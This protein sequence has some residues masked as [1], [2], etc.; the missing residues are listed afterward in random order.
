MGESNKE[1]LGKFIR[2]ETEIAPFKG[3][4][5]ALGI[6]AETQADSPEQSAEEAIDKGLNEAEGISTETRLSLKDVLSSAIAPYLR[7]PKL[8][9]SMIDARTLGLTTPEAIKKFLKVH[10]LDMENKEDMEYLQTVFTESADFYDNY[11]R[12]GKQKRL[13]PELRDFKTPEGI[14][15]IFMTS[16]G[17]GN[18]HFITQACALLRTAAVINYME[19]DVKFALAEKIMPELEKTLS[20]NFK[21][22][23]EFT[24]KQQRE[25]GVNGNGKERKSWV[26]MPARSGQIPM[27]IMG[28]ELR[29]KTREQIIVKLLRRAEDRMESILDVLGFRVYTNNASDAM[30]LFYHM[31]FEPGTAIFPGYNIRLSETKNVG[32]DTEKLRMVLGDTQA[33]EDLFK[34]LSVTVDD[35]EILAKKYDPKKDNEYSMPEYRALQ[36]TFDIDL[37]IKDE[38][39]KRRRVNF[40]VEVQIVDLQAKITNEQKAPHG[41]YKNG[42]KAAVIQRVIGN[43][44]ATAF[45]KHK[46]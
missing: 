2:E 46:K 12:E 41:E 14:Y 31:F 9:S 5:R 35:S 27:P 6:V 20:H 32:I 8:K 4:A 3:A 26:F 28:F 18:R 17:E 34:D 36:V 42:Q 39:G 11:I 21:T 29:Q 22:T 44:I 23:S 33:A 16:A 45:E 37:W 19:G 1:Q 40:P 15:R 13:P 43:N 7:G 24:K 30:K 25:N 10:N 38:S